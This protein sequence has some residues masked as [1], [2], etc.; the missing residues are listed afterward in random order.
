MDQSSTGSCQV[1]EGHQDENQSNPPPIPEQV[2]IDDSPVYRIERKLGKGAYG[3]VYVGRAIS[4]STSSDQTAAEAAQV[5]IKFEH[6]DSEGCEGGIPNEWKVYDDL[7]ENHGIPLPRVH[8]KGQQGDYYVMVMDLLGPSLE[9][10]SL[11]NNFRI[12][13]LEA[14]AC[15]AV[16]AIS[17]LEKLHSRGYIHGDIKPDNFLLGPPGTPEEKRLFLTDLGLA[18]RWRDPSTGSHIE[19]NQT[20][21]D[22]RGTILFASVHAQ[23]GRTSSRRNDLESLVYMLVYLMRG[24]HL[25]WQGH[26]GEDM[27]FLVCKQKMATHPEVL[28]DTRTGPYLQLTLFVLNLKFNEEPNYARYISLFHEAIGQNPYIWP[29][30]TDI[31]QKLNDDDEPSREIRMGLEL[32]QWISIYNKRQPI[33]QTYSRYLDD[34]DLLSRIKKG[35]AEGLYV[36]SVAYSSFSKYWALIMDDSAGFTAQIFYFSDGSLPKEWIEEYW[37]KNY[38]ITTVA[39]ADT[40]KILVVMSEGIQWV[41][42]AYHVT[43][44]FPFAWIKKMWEEGFHVTA[45]TTSGSRWV[46]IWT[47]GTKF[48]NQAVELDFEY[49]AEGIYERS[50]QGYHITSVAATPDEVAFIFSKIKGAP[51]TAIVKQET[52]RTPSFPN[53]D[54]IEER[55][56]RNYYVSTLCYG[57][58]IA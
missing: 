48:T 58:T 26:Q 51:A 38:Y 49:P 24:R 35:Y 5:A 41:Q 37:S 40:G 39:G 7:G 4:P 19:Y 31:A 9:E 25:P 46:V 11:V 18:T 36:T 45:M 33:N 14:I 6:K 27:P 32:S 55:R 50:K 2:Q 21:D 52:L 8:Y 43:S 12:F 17:I 54:V 20:P 1:N 29:V 44:T 15:I 34:D 10:A 28:W 47:N 16:E 23:L 3:Q 22:F 56:A 13:P 30:H 53:Y 42:Q 57:R